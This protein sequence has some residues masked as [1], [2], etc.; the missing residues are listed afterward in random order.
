MCV[1]PPEGK[2]KRNTENT[3]ITDGV[4]EG[5]LV[6]CVWKC[7]PYWPLHSGL[8]LRNTSELL[9]LADLWCSD[10]LGCGE[11]PG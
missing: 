5:E 3:A 8:L 7:L 1:W 10:V 11:L 4:T 2:D 9:M 6:G